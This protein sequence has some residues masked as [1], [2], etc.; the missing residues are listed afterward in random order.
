MIRTAGST[1]GN[2]RGSIIQTAIPISSTFAEAPC[3]DRTSVQ[4]RLAAA[5]DQAAADRQRVGVKPP[6][7]GK[8]R[9][10][11]GDAGWW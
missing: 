8:Q 3:N 5:L 2:T 9:I 4:A 6:E 11:A 7:F 10:D 1:R